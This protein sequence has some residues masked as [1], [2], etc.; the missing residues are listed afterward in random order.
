MVRSL[1]FR[2]AVLYRTALRF[3]PLRREN[4]P[5]ATDFVIISMTDRKHALMCEQMLASIGRI[6]S[7]FP[8]IRLLVDERRGPVNFDRLQRSYSGRIEA[9]AWEVITTQHL[10]KSRPELV[11]FAEGNLLGRKLAFI[12]ASAEQQRTL[13]VDNDILFFRDFVPLVRTQTAGTF[14]GATRDSSFGHKG[15]F[16]GYAPKLARHLFKDQSDIP[17]INTGLCLCNGPVYEAFEL[18]SLVRHTLEIREQNYFTE[19]T[20]LAWAALQ[21]RGVIW[22]TQIV[23]LD[24]TDIYRLRPLPG[25][26]LWCARHYTGNIRH[27]FWRDAFFLHSKA[28]SRKAQP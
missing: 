23:R 22:D 12:A 24:D 11:N 6:W 28:A 20:V 26:E 25:Q 27:L 2:S 5:S 7:E 9:V 13:W 4:K 16:C 8:T 19:Q 21:S 18:S 17:S 1:A 14:V 15:L 3:A 10:Q